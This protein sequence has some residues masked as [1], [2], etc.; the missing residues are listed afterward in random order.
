MQ[1]AGQVAQAK[2]C[3]E[4]F[5]AP[6]FA[7]AQQV[8]A[9]LVGRRR[10]QCHAYQRVQRGQAVA[11]Q[12]HLH[13]H[14]AQ[15][16]QAGDGALGAHAAAAQRGFHTQREGTVVVAPGQHTAAAAG[17]RQ[18]LAFEYALGAEHHAR[19]GIGRT[20]RRRHGGQGNAHLGVLAHVGVAHLAAVQHQVAHGD[21][22]VLV[23]L[24]AVQQPGLAAVCGLFKEDAR[25]RQP[26]LGEGQ[27]PL[28]QLAQVDADFHRVG[29]QHLRLCGPGRVG[30]THR[31]RADAG[32]GPG[33]M[34]L[35]FA[36]DVQGPASL[37]QS[38]VLQ[39]HTRPVKTKDGHGQDH[40][41]RHGQQ[42]TAH[43]QQPIQKVTFH[44]WLLKDC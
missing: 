42:H 26:H 41:H 12:V 6:G 38:L 30:E 35:Q 20:H 18:G 21:A 43:K 24:Q 33:P 44:A 31:L 34:Q 8:A 13:V 2:T 22:R 3:G 10:R 40:Q 28:Q 17:G 1:I 16:Q 27:P 19:L 29:R 5:I 32:C 36:A 11:G 4:F 7:A 25:A 37:L 23:G 15:V 14:R 39:R 9:A